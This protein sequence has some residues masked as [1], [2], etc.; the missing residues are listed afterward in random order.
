MRLLLF[1]WLLPFALISLGT[2]KLFHYAYPFLPPIALATGWITAKAVSAVNG[3]FGAMLAARLESSKLLGR[4]RRVGLV[5]AVLVSLALVAIALAVASAVQGQVV[6]RV[7][8]V[9]LLQNSTVVRPLLIAALL[10]AFAGLARWSIQTLA[11]LGLL[12]T[13][14]VLAYSGLATF[15]MTI[16]A[17]LRTIRACATEVHAA[18]P[19]SAVGFLNSARAQSNHSDYYYLSRVGQWLEPETVDLE[20]IRRRLFEPGEQLPVRMTRATYPVWRQQL[21]SDARRQDFPP[22]VVVGDSVF[23]FPGPYAPCAAAAADAVSDRLVPPG[24]RRP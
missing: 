7:A 14:P 21:S 8:G 17:R 9:R 3:P 13:L 6:W 2:S 5:R 20:T 18:N 11:A 16:D 24:E 12:L 19:G 23:V 1:W 15:A 10:L 22:A 4:G